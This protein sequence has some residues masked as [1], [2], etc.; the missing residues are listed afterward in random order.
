MK[1]WL[2][3]I[4]LGL[5]GIIAVVLVVGAFT[6][7]THVSSIRRQHRKSLRRRATRRSRAP[8][9]PPPSSG[10]STSPGRWR[11]APLNDCHGRGLRRWSSHGRWARGDDDG[12]QHHSDL[13]AAYSDGELARLNPPWSE[14]G[15]TDRAFHV[16]ARV[17]LVAGRRRRCADF[18]PPHR[19]ARRARVGQQQYQNLGQG[20][21]SQRSH[22]I[23]I[24]LAAST[25]RTLPI[26][27]EPAPTAEYGRWIA[28]QCS[29][30]HG[31][32]FSGGPIP[33]T[34]PDFPVP[35]N[36]HAHATG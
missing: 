31:E 18:L 11:A 23:D 17:Q 15:S 12:S 6:V 35:L 21:G 26:G 36:P 7:Y 19:P 4:G 9:S 22:P 25:T 24:A 14:E 27:P 30:C 32:H 5:L 28:R 20:S 8:A 3:R 29:G 13:A 33:G 1:R 34:P 16:H 10:A 2:K